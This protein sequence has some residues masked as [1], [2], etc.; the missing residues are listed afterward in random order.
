M[1]P[2]NEINRALKVVEPK[3]EESTN[4]LKRENQRLLSDIKFLED[5]N[6]N[7]QVQR[8]FDGKTIQKQADELN[9]LKKALKE[10][11][12]EIQK[13]IKEGVPGNTKSNTKLIK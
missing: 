8:E 6:H 9:K 10:R 12:T 1:G 13:L 2:L 3:I 4:E 11:E 7:L 5:Q